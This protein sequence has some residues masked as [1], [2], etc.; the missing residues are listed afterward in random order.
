MIGEAMTLE[1]TIIDNAS[2]AVPEAPLESLSAARTLRKMG[3][4]YGVNR[5]DLIV[6]DV[7]GDWPEQWG[8]D[9]GE[10]PDQ[11]SVLNHGSSLL[12]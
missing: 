3:C 2:S 7:E 5:I 10:I 11:P 9:I 6:E 1:Y 12:G 4:S 8:E